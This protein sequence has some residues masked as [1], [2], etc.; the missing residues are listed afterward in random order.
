V[1]ARGPEP[2]DLAALQRAQ[3]LR[4]ERGIEIADLVEEERA[5]VG[6][7]EPPGTGLGGTGE[8]PLLVAEELA[9]DEAR[10]QLTVISGRSGRVLRAWIACANSSLPTPVSP[11][12]NTGTSVPAT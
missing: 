5:A 7:L 11:S 4:L 12:S 6:E 8:R 2:L 9:L 10:R 1:G 3:Q